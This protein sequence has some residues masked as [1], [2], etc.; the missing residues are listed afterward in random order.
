MSEKYPKLLLLGFSLILAFVLVVER[1]FAPLQTILFSLGYVGTFIAGLLYAYS[2]TAILATALLLLLAREQNV[3]FAGLIAGMGAI[4]G[5]FLFF[6]LMRGSF[7]QELHQL[8]KEKVI[9]RLGKPFH[10]HKRHALI[11]LAGIIISSP[12]PTEVGIALLSSLKEMTTKRFLA[13]VFLLHTFGIFV[14]L[15]IGAQK[16][17]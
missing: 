8:S 7:S 16:I 9:A 15:L 11:A 4:L 12:L 2:F 6:K 13:V 3:I 17:F 14:I 10:R 1:D 5:D